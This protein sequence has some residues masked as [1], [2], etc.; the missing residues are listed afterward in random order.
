MDALKWEEK[1]TDEMKKQK[2]LFWFNLMRDS[3]YKSKDSKEMM[4]YAN[5]IKI[6]LRKNAEYLEK[7]LY[8]PS[9]LKPLEHFTNR[10]LSMHDDCAAQITLVLDTAPIVTA[11][12]VTNRID[13]MA[14]IQIINESGEADGSKVKVGYKDNMYSIDEYNSIINKDSLYQLH[15]GIKNKRIIFFVIILM[16]IVIIIV[17]VCVYL[18]KNSNKNKEA[19]KTE[20]I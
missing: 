4:E 15:G 16:A 18:S 1:N 8:Q 14:T 6:L 7:Y 3:R 9:D 2:K 10:E 20:Q 5:N 13:R 17:S 11:C 12:F 19:N